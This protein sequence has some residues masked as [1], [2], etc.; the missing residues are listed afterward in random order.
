MPRINILGVNDVENLQNFNRKPKASP[1]DRQ[2]GGHDA[3]RISKNSTKS[4]N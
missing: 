4:L 1:Q 3:S 2:G